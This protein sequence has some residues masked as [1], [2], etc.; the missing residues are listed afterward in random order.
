MTEPGNH[1][2]T[3]GRNVTIANVR[4]LAGGGGQIIYY[5]T[6]IGILS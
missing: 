2:N 5:K 1:G 3:G 6:T 4:R